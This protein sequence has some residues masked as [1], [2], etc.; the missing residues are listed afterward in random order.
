[1]KILCA[2]PS[3]QFLSYQDD[4]EAAVVRVL[5]GSQY[6]LGEEVSSLESE[7]AE[8]IGTEHA[9]GVAN[10]TDALELALRA[11]NIGPGDEVITV[12]HTAVATVAAIHAVGAVPVL[13]DIK[14]NTYTIDSDQLKTLV[15]PKTKA[16]IAVHIYG[17]PADLDA[18][19]GFCKAHKIHLIEDASQAHG[20]Y[21]KG[22]KIGTF[23]VINCFS[24]YPTK[25]L[26]AIGD[27]GLITTNSQELNTKIRMLREY[28]W[29]D[30]Y[31]SQI[32]GRN[33]RL[34]EL[35]AAI[36]RIK[37]RHLSADNSKREAIALRYSNGIKNSLVSLPFI[38]GHAK[39]A[40]HL[41]VLRALNRDAL[42]EHL[43]ANNV[44]P[45]IH[46]PVPIH[47]Q[48]A[49]KNNIRIA[50]SMNVTESVASQVISLP[51][52]PELDFDSV[53]FVIELINSL[54]FHGN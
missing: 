39:P 8:F 37:L 33:S 49:Y 30:R 51:I 35:Q 7:F 36:L 43:R 38:D 20:A 21:W 50:S 32:P 16:L 15:S 23:G 52:Y 53:D 18:V 54:S 41:Y 25:N 22:Q 45:G 1:L 17:H 11:L 9:I 5:R 13:A 42:L 46:Y 6:V 44:Y 34:D 14:L 24:C 19:E 31:I 48:P 12:S 10:G 4:I 27:A 28:G 3:K 2:N 47:L 40:Y 26:G 29:K